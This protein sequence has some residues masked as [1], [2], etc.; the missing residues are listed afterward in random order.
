MAVEALIKLIPAFTIIGWDV[1]VKSVVAPDETD[2][3]LEEI[4]GKLKVD[5]ANQELDED[6]DVGGPSEHLDGVIDKK[7]D[8]K[9][10]S[11]AAKK[12]AQQR[13]NSGGG[14]QTSTPLQPTSSGQDSKRN[15]GNNKKTS[16]KKSPKRSR[17]PR[18]PS[19]TP[20]QQKKKKG[21]KKKKGAAPG[22]SDIVVSPHTTFVQ[23]QG[24]RG[25]ANSGGKGSNRK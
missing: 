14:G 1:H 25:G 7:I 8:S 9:L 22:G 6:M 3:E 12:K 16:R 11:V 10:A 13:K 2:A 23:K 19:P 17:S 15:S 4:F 20:T 24:S 18:S 21:K 5:K